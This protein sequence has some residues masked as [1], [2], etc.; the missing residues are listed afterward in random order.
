MGSTLFHTI[1]GL[2]SGLESADEPEAHSIIG[3]YIYRND[4]GTC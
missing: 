1:P 4:G 3:D 2:T